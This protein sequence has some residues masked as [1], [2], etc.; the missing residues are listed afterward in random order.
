M[1]KCICSAANMHSSMKHLSMLRAGLPPFFLI[2]LFLLIWLL[3]GKITCFCSFPVVTSLL[4]L[5]TSPRFLDTLLHSAFLS[6]SCLLL[7]ADCPSSQIHSQVAGWGLYHIDNMKYF[8]LCFLY[9]SCILHI[10]TLL[11]RLPVWWETL[12]SNVG[13]NEMT[14]VEK[15]KAHSALMFQVW[16]L[17]ADPFCALRPK[18]WPSPERLPLSIM[19]EERVGG[20]LCSVNSFFLN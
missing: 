8:I 11:L 18:A 2:F 5:G 19:S 15:T 12:K 7:W 17:T 14:A 6:L 3:K 13:K 4:S 20:S 1:C 9:I 16:G 10:I